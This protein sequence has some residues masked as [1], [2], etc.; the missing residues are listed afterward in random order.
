MTA[1]TAAM[2]G[3]IHSLAP[4]HWLP[5]VMVARARKWGLKASI[6]GAI[7]ASLGHILL[8]LILAIVAISAGEMILHERAE[9][10]EHYASL[11]LVIFGLGYAIWAYR[12]HRTCAH[13]HSHHGPAIRRKQSPYLFL[14]LAGLSPCVAAFPVFVTA[15][16]HGVPSLGLS[17]GMFAGGVVLAL[18]A[19]TLVAVAG[20]KRIQFDHPILEHHADTITGL[21]V[22]CLGIVLYFL[23][24]AH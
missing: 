20:V 18:T 19:T 24:H 5:V 15:A 21:S 14:F 9:W 4:G 1:L 22:A 8:S 7:V 3:L 16:T 6:I 11:G 17:M 13:E 10:I 2:V 23:P 12:T